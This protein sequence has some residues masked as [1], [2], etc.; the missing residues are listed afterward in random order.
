MTVTVR[1]NTTS[2]DW[3]SFGWNRF[4]SSPS[5]NDFSI[6]M[7]KKDEFNGSVALEMDEWNTFNTDLY[8]QL[9]LGM[10]DQALSSVIKPISMGFSLPYESYVSP[11]AMSETQREAAI[12]L[13]D[14]WLA[15]ESGY[16]FKVW[17]ELRESIEE[18]RL[19]YRKRFDG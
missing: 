7:E 4:S 2:G 9:A 14:E 11:I 5:G 12:R 10:F 17:G 15:D 16:D 6:L 3:L 1:Q 18:N 19:S 13:I 8:L